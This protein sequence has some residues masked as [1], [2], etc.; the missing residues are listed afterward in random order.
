MANNRMAIVC[1]DCNKGISIAKFYPQGGFLEGEESGWGQY[2][3]N[4][5]RVNDFFITHAHEH[6]KS[7]WGENQYE[8]RYE[9]DDNTWEYEKS[10]C[11]CK[12]VEETPEPFSIGGFKIDKNCPEH[13]DLLHQISGRGKLTG[14]YNEPPS[15]KELIPIVIFIGIP[16]SLIFALIV[17][18]IKSL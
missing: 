18:V 16:L 15:W 3:L 1:K 2:P 8:L 4:E 6:D 9:I 12:L 17:I 7:M 11:I 14:I 5:N 10:K 13:E